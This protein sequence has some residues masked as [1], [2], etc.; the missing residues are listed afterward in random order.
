MDVSYLTFKDSQ[1][2]ADL[3]HLIIHCIFANKALDL[4]DKLLEQV[5]ITSRVAVFHEEVENDEQQLLQNFFPFR[6]KSPFH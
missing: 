3:N 5:P 6:L 2:K 1:V 4:K